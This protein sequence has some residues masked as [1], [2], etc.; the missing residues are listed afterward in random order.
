MKR[1]GRE[2]R[3]E[4]LPKE[5]CLPKDSIHEGI[6]YGFLPAYL[7]P[8]L[9]SLLPPSFLLSLLLLI[10]TPCA[11]LCLWISGSLLLSISI[12]SVGW[13]AVSLQPLDAM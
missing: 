13:L 10:R 5:L 3:E 9:L 4:G 7:P 1:G 11:S 2:G 12:Q 8:F 6:Y